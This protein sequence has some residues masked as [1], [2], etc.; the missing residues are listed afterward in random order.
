MR[1]GGSGAPPGLCGV[2][3]SASDAV[4]AAEEGST[5]SCG[6]AKTEHGEAASKNLRDALGVVEG[7]VAFAEGEGIDDDGQ[8]ESEAGHAHDGKEG[9]ENGKN[10]A[11]GSNVGLPL[12]VA[13]LGRLVAMKVTFS[14]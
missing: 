10:C 7:V 13:P 12:D 11:H 8:A 14:D 1:E 2:L 6:D 9:S 5:E 3:E 4:K